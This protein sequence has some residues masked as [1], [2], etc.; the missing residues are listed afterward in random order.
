MN[1]WSISILIEDEF[2]NLYCEYFEDFNGYL[3]SSLFQ[4]ENQKKKKLTPKFMTKKNISLGEFH[5]NEFWVLEILLNEEPSMNEVKLK[6][7]L[8]AK[9]LKTEEYTIEDNS[10]SYL[11]KFNTINIKKVINQNWI[12][13][14]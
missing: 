2:K 7:N 6:L 12:I 3:S 10:L 13:E 8:L 14:N 11:V 9:E 4:Q 1:L 5:E